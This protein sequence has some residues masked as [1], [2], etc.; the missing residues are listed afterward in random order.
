MHDLH[1]SA[2]PPGISLSVHI[3]PSRRL[4]MLLFLAALVYAGAACCILSRA[5]SIAAPWL[6]AGACCAAA[7]LLAGTARQ[8]L[9]MRRIDISK[10]HAVRLTVQLKLPD[11]GR[12]VRLLPGSL[13]WGQLMVLRFGSVDNAAAPPQTVVVLPDSTGREAFR[14]LAVAMRAIAGHSGAEDVQKIG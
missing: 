12:R 2:V 1:D 8:P 10:A 11:A 7:V 14:A 3:A 6:V 9:K 13:L 5:S 4:R